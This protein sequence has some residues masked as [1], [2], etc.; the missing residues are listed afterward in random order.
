MFVRAN[1]AA[2]RHVM[3]GASTVT[4]QSIITQP[5]TSRFLS[6]T[7]VGVLYTMTIGFP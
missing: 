6:A 4:Y 5:I 7:T 1:T 2:Q 3:G